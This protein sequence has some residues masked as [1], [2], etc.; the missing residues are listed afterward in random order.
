M[1]DCIR[2][3]KASLRCTVNQVRRDA[4]ILTEVIF[5]FESFENLWGRAVA[6]LSDQGVVA[7]IFSKL[8]DPWCDDH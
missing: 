6:V 7:W 5:F 1:L 4:Q 8:L 3:P 2:C